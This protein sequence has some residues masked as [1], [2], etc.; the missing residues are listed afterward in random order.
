LLA[1]AWVVA[2]RAQNVGDKLPAPAK[3]DV[4]K[5]EELV[6]GIY[7]DEFKKAEDNKAAAKE[8]ASALL[9]QAQE[10][11]D[12]PAVKFAALALARDAAVKAGDHDLAFQII[13]EIARAFDVGTA[14][15][16]G[17]IL[18][19]VVENA[20]D[21]HEKL[22]ETALVLVRQALDEDD[23]QGAEGLVATAEKVADA[24]KNEKLAARVEIA[25][26]EVKAVQKESERVKPFLAKLEK[27]P[28][29]A[30]ANAD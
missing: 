7:K 22:A 19:V 11:K 21:G 17:A 10:T 4:A 13:D 29:D 2:L 16:R 24:Y 9:K 1:V 18:A 26:A 23:Y 5:A 20:A 27:E 12:D 14:G 25:R 28:D 8:L 6:R 15:M 3:A 30:E